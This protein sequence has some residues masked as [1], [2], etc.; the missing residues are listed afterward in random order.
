MIPLFP[1][2][3]SLTT[4]HK[5]T[6]DRMTKKFP[7]YSDFN[8]TSLWSW[9]IRS[10]IKISKLND[11]LVVLFSD[12][13]TNTKFLSFIGD[14]KVIETAFELLFYSKKKYHKNYLKLIP[15]ELALYFKFKHSPFT[16]HINRDD[17]DYVYLADHLAS[18]REWR[19]HSKGKALRKRLAEFPEYKVSIETMDKIDRQ[20]Y[21]AMFHKWSLHKHDD[22]AFELNEYKAFQRFLEL[23]DK[24]IVFISI[25]IK[26]VLAGF[27]AYE[28]LPNHYA[29]AHFSK[30][31]IKDFP[32]I[33]E[34]LNWEEGRELQKR[35]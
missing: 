10:K 7:P 4:S 15:E 26:G 31:D 32:G 18:M 12:Y 6:I 11:N 25:Y 23:T 27:S 28:L 8:F 2:F 22:H 19:S 16:V 24:K 9:N 5:Q 3:T 13:V 35:K 14:N 30:A 34:I 20:A 29:L 21:R 1:T 33:Y 17:A